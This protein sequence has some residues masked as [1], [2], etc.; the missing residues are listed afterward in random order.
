MCA[1]TTSEKKD[2]EE[3]K[4]T[5]KRMSFRCGCAH[6][7]GDRLLSCELEP[8]PTV[9]YVASKPVLV[10]VPLHLSKAL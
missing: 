2:L 4:E 9:S 10:T 8:A 1:D 6:N 7:L 5:R 3:E